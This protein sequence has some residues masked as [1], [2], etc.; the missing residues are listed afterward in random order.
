MVGIRFVSYYT[1]A[2]CSVH[3]SVVCVCVWEGGVDRKHK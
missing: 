2:G 3:V 1:E